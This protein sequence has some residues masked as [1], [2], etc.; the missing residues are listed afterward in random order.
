MALWK[1]ALFYAGAEGAGKTMARTIDWL[2]R[3]AKR[4]PVRWK[5]WILREK[6]AREIANR[7]K[8]K[9]LYILSYSFD[10][11]TPLFQRPHQLAVALS[12]RKNAHVIFLS[13]QYRFDNFAGL[14]TVNAS[15]D[16][17]PLHFFLKNP[18]ILQTAEHIT[19]F[20]SLPI[21]MELLERIQYDTLVYDYIDDLSLLPYCT[22]ET[23]ELHYKLI[24]SAD[25][26]VCTAKTLYEDACLHTKRVILSPNACDYDFFHASRNC[27]PDMTITELTKGYDCVLG[28][29][30]CLAQWLDSEL[31]K[32]V[33]VE[34][35]NWCFLLMGQCFDGSDQRLKE[36][37]MSNIILWPAQ[38]YKDLPRFVAAFDIQMIPFKVN[39]ITQ[40]TSPVKLFE[41]MA[42]GKPIL[43][44]AMPECMR[45]RSVEIYRTAEEFIEKVEK[46]RTLLPDAEYFADMDLEAKENTW[47]ARVEEIVAYVRESGTDGK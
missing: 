36:A 20:K 42:V 19:V 46:L 27:E 3:K 41:Y 30:G 31:L 33:A 4:L 1:K 32:Q 6:Y 2:V 39:Q 35:P 40:G 12:Q 5:E 23:K 13:D 14:M 17:I 8:G 45:Y 21:Q 18:D 26:T 7:L 24:E 16:V 34:R 29:Y 47:K 9:E 15:L 11:N 10:W 37:G 38:P 44:S 22:A 43:T 28:Y 25:L